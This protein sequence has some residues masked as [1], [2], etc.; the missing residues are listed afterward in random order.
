M[1]VRA[2]H[3]INVDDIGQKIYLFSPPAFVM[4]SAH[5][6]RMILESNQVSVCST[7]EYP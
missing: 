1:S 2:D 5:L 6:A 4:R 3:L 7:K